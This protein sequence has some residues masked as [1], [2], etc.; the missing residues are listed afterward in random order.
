MTAVSISERVIPIIF[1]GGSYGHF[2]AW[3]LCYFSGKTNELP[4]NKTGNSHLFTENDFKSHG[5]IKIHPK[6]PDDVY[7]DYVL[8]ERLNYIANKY[9]SGIFLYANYDLFLLNINNKFSKIFTETSGGWLGWVESNNVDMANDLK[10]WQV[11]NLDSMQQ[12]Q[13]RE[14]LSY[15]IW[16]QHEKE[17]EIDTILHYHNDSIIKIDIKQLISEFQLTIERLLDYCNFTK[18]RSNFEEIYEIWVKLQTH[19]H[20]DQIV[21]SIIKNVIDDTDFEWSDKNLSIVDEAIIQFKLR[22]L[23]DFDLLCY[24][25]N[26]FPTNT[27]DLKKYLKPPLE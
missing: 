3:C 2:V 10:K 18:S 4:F 25:L 12:W 9:G 22:E 27:A 11:D 15:F 17:I 26:E 16:K 1:N 8:K 19:I 6:H 5:L 14:F 23:F 7:K 20:K 13:I 24:N 21:E